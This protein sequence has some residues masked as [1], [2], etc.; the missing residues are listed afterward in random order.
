M[1]TKFTKSEIF[2]VYN[3]L[4]SLA[5]K[6]GDAKK[7]DRLNKALGILMSNSYYDGDKSTYSPSAESCGCKDWEFH[8]AARRAYT[9]PCKHM[10]AELMISMILERREAHN[11]TAK[12]VVEAPKFQH[13]YVLF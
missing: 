7:I 4:K 3:Q 11:V 5:R 6:D 12:P 8:Y 9:G 1:T 10:L 13:K 2:T